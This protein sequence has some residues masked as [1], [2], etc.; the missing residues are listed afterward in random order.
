VGETAVPAVEASS[1]LPHGSGETVMIVDDERPLVALAEEIIANLG[2][3]PVGFDSSSAALESFRAA[4]DRFDLVLTDESMP[5]M[6]GTELAQAIRRLRP[7]IPIILMTGYGGTQLANR[8][9][10]V[11]LNEVLRKPLHRRDLAES[12]ARVLVSVH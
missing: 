9:V 1:T 4:P 7:N 12:L 2:Y 11:G 8:A 10:D 5:D 6:L 3:E